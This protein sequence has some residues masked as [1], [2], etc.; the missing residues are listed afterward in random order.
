MGCLSNHGFL[1]FRQPAPLFRKEIISH[2]AAV[3]IAG[4]CE[5]C[6]FIARHYD[7]FLE[8]GLSCSITW[9][10]CSC[11]FRFKHFHHLVGCG[12]C[13]IFLEK[14]VT[15]SGRRSVRSLLFCLFSVIGNSF[16]FNSSFSPLSLAC[17]VSFRKFSPVKRIG[18][19]ISST[20]S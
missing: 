10:V 1:H 6:F 4:K 7:D 14:A 18:R 5:F 12:G 3:C 11:G 13:G 16:H 17:A 8:L 9:L 15:Q 19:H 2:G 20:R